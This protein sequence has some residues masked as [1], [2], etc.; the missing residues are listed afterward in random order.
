MVV[1][2][3]FTPDTLAA[4]GLEPTANI[5]LPKVVLFQMNHI[6]ATMIAAYNTYHGTVTLE[7]PSPFSPSMREQFHV[8][9]SGKHDPVPLHLGIPYRYLSSA[10]KHHAPSVSSY[11]FPF[12]DS[13]QTYAKRSL[14]LILL[15]RMLHMGYI[16]C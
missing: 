12:F 13:S 5:F 9:R 8:L 16:S 7:V 10:A 14:I 15:L 3:T 6:R 11:P 2:I 4:S 1:F